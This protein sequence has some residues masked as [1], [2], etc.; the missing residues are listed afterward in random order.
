MFTLLAMGFIDRVG[1]R[2]LM[3][4]GSAGLIATLGLVSWSFYQQSFSVW[5]VPVFLFIYIAFFA[6][7]QGAVIWVFISEIF[8]TQ[9]RAKGQTLGSTTH[10][11]MAAVIAFSFPY[12]AEKV[13]GGNTFLF[14]AIMMV[15]Q[16]LF[17]WKL[18]PETKGKS[19]E[20]IEHSLILH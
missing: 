15:L 6:F 2:S 14:F 16:M 19:L 8:P 9:V 5:S 12:L 20:Q 11:V 7:S 3:M 17:V 13:G 1:R 18:M 10:W 4:I